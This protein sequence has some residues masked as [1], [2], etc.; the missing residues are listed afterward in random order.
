MRQRSVVTAAVVP[1]AAVSLAACGS[2]KSPS[3]AGTSPTPSMTMSMPMT[4][5]PS[6]SPSPTVI[7]DYGMTPAA[8]IDQQARDA[9]KSLNT[10][11]VSGTVDSS[12]KPVTIDLR[13]SKGGGC[14]GTITLAG[15]SVEIIGAGGNFYMK[16]SMAFWTAQANAA[17]AAKVGGKWITGFSG[18]QFAQFCDLNSV[19]KSMATDPVAKDRP[20]VLGMNTLS[21]VS[22]VELQ[23]HDK[24][25]VSI[26]SVSA[27]APHY[28]LQ[29]IAS[30]DKSAMSFSDFNVPF[31]ATA[32]MG[33]VDIRTL[34]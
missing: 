5:S 26:L 31:T 17:T 10:L 8:V 1:L 32:P 15:Q 30:A 7:N 22:V 29:V 18:G 20:K 21:G 16:G 4:P 9:L 27:A 25:G 11:H 19:A 12:S 33:A 23:V 13:I 14:Q 6:V 34:K 28:P 3:A 2:S 24:T